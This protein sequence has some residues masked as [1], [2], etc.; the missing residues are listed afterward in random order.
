[1]WVYIIFIRKDFC[2]II[3]YTTRNVVPCITRD[4]MYTFKKHSVRYYVTHVII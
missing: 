1:M 4:I 3:S 2:V